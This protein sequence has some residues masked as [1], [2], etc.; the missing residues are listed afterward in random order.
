MAFLN[1]FGYYKLGA[2]TCTRDKNFCLTS[3]YK[4][5]KSMQIYYEKSFR[6]QFG[7]VLINMVKYFN[8]F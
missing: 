3:P 8:Y 6:N 2:D 4:I 1:Q 5:Y 7:K